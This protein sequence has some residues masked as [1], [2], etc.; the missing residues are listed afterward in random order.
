MYLCGCRWVVCEH[1]RRFDDATVPSRDAN[2]VRKT[3]WQSFPIR[4][5]AAS[6]GGGF[7]SVFY[8]HVVSWQIKSA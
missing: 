8:S 2:F 6:G 1:T 5:A 7:C 4:P 3:V